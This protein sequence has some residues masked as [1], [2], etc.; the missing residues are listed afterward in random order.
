LYLKQAAA[1]NQSTMFITDSK[2]EQIKVTDLDASLRQVELF[3]NLTHE[4]PSFITLDTELKTYW[5]DI[6]QKLLTLKEK[7]K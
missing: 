2:G 4:D 7:L 1:Q 5:Q 3:V 6:K